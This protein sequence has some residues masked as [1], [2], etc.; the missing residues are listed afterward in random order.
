MNFENVNDFIDEIRSDYDDK[1]VVT[2]EH[3]DDAGKG[4][5]VIRTGS[6]SLDISLGVGGLP[7]GKITELYGPEGTGKSTLACSVAKNTIAN[8]E[9]VLYVDVENMLDLNYT[10]QLL[11]GLYTPQSMVITQ[12]EV[13]EDAMEIVERGI[14]SG[15][16]GLVVVD[17]IAALSSR[18][19]QMKDLEDSTMAE[20]ARL[21]SKFFRRN[22]P[23]IRR[24]NVA[25][26]LTN[27]IRDKIGGYSH[28]YATPGGW[29]L[30]HYTSIRIQLYSAQKIM[31]GKE[32]IG[33]L[34][35]F[36][37]KKNKVAPPFRSHEIP[38]IFGKGIDTAR[39]TVEFA[40]VLGVV[41]TRGSYYY[42]NDDRI[43]H[44]LNNTLE[45]MEENEEVLDNIREM[46]YNVIVNKRE[47]VEDSEEIVEDLID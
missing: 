42:F 17:S 23:H 37:I 46:C 8:G 5:D 2:Q 3:V 28:G 35:P 47:L 7:K 22:S 9:A 10:K 26:L 27:Q 12:P 24:S 33:I 43:G 25:L 1:I 20:V 31:E 6:T 34:T 14:R 29:S 40:K 21:L 44:G 38:F 32:Q 16:F 18:R 45:Y 15:S 4:L 36:S 39:D 13:G 11:D 41:K 19:E 30:K